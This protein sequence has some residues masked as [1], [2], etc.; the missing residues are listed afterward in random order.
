MINRTAFVA[1]GEK[2]ISQSIAV[3][4]NPTIQIHGDHLCESQCQHFT[5]LK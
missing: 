5:S 3:G 1:L 4:L 2:L